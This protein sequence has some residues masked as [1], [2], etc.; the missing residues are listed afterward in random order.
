V[1]KHPVYIIEM[2]VLPDDSTTGDGYRRL[3]AFLKA[4]A[5][6]W[7]LQCISI[8]PATHPETPAG[9]IVPKSTEVSK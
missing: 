1:S 3:R 6:S 8:K 5:R 7:R 2:K 4:A 9:T